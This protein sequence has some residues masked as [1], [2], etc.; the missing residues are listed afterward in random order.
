[1][2]LAACRQ[3]W[4]QNIKLSPFLRFNRYFVPQTPG[5]LH[6]YQVNIRWNRTISRNV[7]VNNHFVCKSQSLPRS[8]KRY[9]VFNYSCTTRIRLLLNYSWK[10]CIARMFRNDKNLSTISAVYHNLARL[11]AQICLP[12]RCY[13]VS[14]L[15][16]ID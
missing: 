1:M 7:W 6:N 10:E 9:I 3:T 4:T 5:H 16:I 11:N 15:S 2:H 13:L 8:T 14:A 12:K